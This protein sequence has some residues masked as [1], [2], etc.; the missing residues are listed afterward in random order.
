MILSI[1]ALLT[2]DMGVTYL[3]LQSKIFNI[4]HV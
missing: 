1:I 3:Q 4:V 2:K